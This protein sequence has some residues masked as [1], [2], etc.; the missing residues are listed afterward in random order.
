MSAKE[1][2]SRKNQNRLYSKGKKNLV[3]DAIVHPLAEKNPVFIIL[4]EVLHVLIEKDVTVSA[5]KF[6][7]YTVPFI[8][9]RYAKKRG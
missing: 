7:K 9:K 5:Q 2:T 1:K 3:V 8:L 4:D 6:A